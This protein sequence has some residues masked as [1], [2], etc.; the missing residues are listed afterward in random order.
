MFTD[1]TEIHKCLIRFEEFEEEL[2]EK[3]SWIFSKAAAP[4]A[5][6]SSASPA[7]S[8]RRRASA[9][10]ET[11]GSAGRMSRFYAVPPKSYKWLPIIDP[12]LSQLRAPSKLV[13]DCK[14]LLI[15]FHLKA[16][17]VPIVALQLFPLSTF[18]KPYCRLH[19]IQ[20]S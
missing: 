14:L 7:S 4:I 10:S 18:L 19:F 5:S 15:F 2:G 16:W 20:R 6:S 12:L 8:A 11:P 17:I 1:L 13:G 3:Q 9:T